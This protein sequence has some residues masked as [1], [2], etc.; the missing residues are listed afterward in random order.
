MSPTK[1]R[2]KTP[3]FIKKVLADVKK[4]QVER[5][6]R[7]EAPPPDLTPNTCIVAF[8]DILGFGREIERA[9]TKADLEA[10]YKKV[11]TVQKEFQNISAVE[12][13]EE[14]RTTHQLYGKKVLALSDSIVIAIYPTA[15]AAAM[16]G[17]ADLLGFSLFEILL[18]QS[19]CVA[20]HGIFVRGGI[21]HGPFFFENDVLLS[22]ALARAYELESEFAQ[23]PVIVV[24]DETRQLITSA[25][26]KG[27]YSPGADP[28]PQYFAPLGRRKW[29]GRPLYFLDYMSIM[30]EEQ[31]RGMLPE[32]RAQYIAANKA[33]DTKRAQAI[34]DRSALKDAEFFLKWHRKRIENAYNSVP[35]EKVRKKYRWLMKYHNRSFPNDRKYLR[36][37]VIDLSKFGA[38]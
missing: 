26:R 11:Q 12:D 24:P 17:V 33:N 25:P 19:R 29:C 30:I 10:A 31:H 34:L 14:T 38:S 18:G 15:N 7:V 1:K 5:K 23:N 37:Q 2:D 13:P 16:M 20:A 35:V 22:P 3:D 27:S 21:S 28:T 8:I 6:A 4:K 32:D 9:R 36:R